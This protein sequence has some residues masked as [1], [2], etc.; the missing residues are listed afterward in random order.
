MLK[1]ILFKFKR[2]Y[3][4]TVLGVLNIFM[5]S[6][7]LGCSNNPDQKKDHA[8]DSIARVKRINDSLAKE[9]YKQ[10]SLNEIKR[11]QDSITREDSIKK[12]KPIKIKYKQIIHAPK[13]GIPSVTH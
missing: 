11:I 5:F 12:T 10:D 2:S 8:A 1:T 7:L 13:Y 6:F 4:S 3:Y 9:K